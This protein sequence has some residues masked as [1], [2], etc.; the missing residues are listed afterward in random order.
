[1][2]LFSHLMPRSGEHFRLNGC[3]VLLG[4]YILTACSRVPLDVICNQKLLICNLGELTPSFHR[5]ERYR[6]T[7]CP[8]LALTS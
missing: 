5:H 8:C 7:P 6:K 1:M 4:H 3:P 2:A